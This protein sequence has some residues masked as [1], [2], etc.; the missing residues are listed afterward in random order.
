MSGDGVEHIDSEQVPESKQAFARG[1]TEAEGKLK[2]ST[3]VFYRVS[4]HLDSEANKQNRQ[5]PVWLRQMDRAET[6]ADQFSPPK[7]TVT[8]Q[9]RFA[10][11]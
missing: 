1:D 5:R 2:F 6:P 3:I 8:H 7:A 10:I 9:N 11:R 4:A